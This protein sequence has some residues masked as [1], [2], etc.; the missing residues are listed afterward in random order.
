[1]VPDKLNVK[2]I[3]HSLITTPSVSYLNITKV[4]LKSIFETLT[5]DIYKNNY[6][7]NSIIYILW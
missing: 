4:C 3:C 1:M 6:F 2:I 5:N 7:L